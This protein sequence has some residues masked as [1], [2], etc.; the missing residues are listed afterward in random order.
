MTC[1]G[2]LF[3]ESSASLVSSRK[4]GVLFYFSE[5]IYISV[6]YY[7]RYAARYH[8]MGPAVPWH[9]LGHAQGVCAPAAAFPCWRREHWAFFLAPVLYLTNAAV[10]RGRVQSYCRA[11]HWITAFIQGLTYG[12]PHTSVCL[13][14]SCLAFRCECLKQSLVVAA[15]GEMELSVNLKRSLPV[16]EWQWFQIIH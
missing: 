6:C 14:A 9:G 5:V 10:A 15:W 3:R 11:T 1:W 4:L 7:R 13:A 2:L 16:S 12:L 8:R